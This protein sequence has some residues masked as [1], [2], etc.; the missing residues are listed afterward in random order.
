MI[1]EINKISLYFDSNGE[2]TDH[3][4]AYVAYEGKKLVRPLLIGKLTINTDE[5]DYA[6]YNQYQIK[7]EALKK[8]LIAT[9]EYIKSERLYDVT[10]DCYSQHNYVNNMVAQRDIKG[11]YADIMEE[12]L[13]IIDDLGGEVGTVVT[14]STIKGDKNPARK[15]A[16][17]LLT[18]I[19]QKPKQ[20]T[21]AVNTAT[22][23]SKSLEKSKENVK[24]DNKEKIS[25]VIQI[26]QFK[27]M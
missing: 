8:G 2:M 3:G 15:I 22:T 25:N 10:I 27:V 26:E 4:L 23:I 16:G 13:E 20:V 5:E 6:G 19:R 21:V 17:D 12:V 11:V 1:K 18:E 24:E 14:I 9:K 7:L